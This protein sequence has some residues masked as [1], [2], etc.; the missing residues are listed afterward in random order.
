MTEHIANELR[1]L[2]AMLRN[3]T[4]VR[5]SADCGQDGESPGRESK[6]SDALR[7]DAVVAL[8]IPEHM[9]DGR[10]ELSGTPIKERI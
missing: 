5:L 4:Q 7:V 10:V 8:P 1:G 9:V 6:R 3:N 2:G